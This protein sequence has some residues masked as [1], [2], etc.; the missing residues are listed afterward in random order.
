MDNYKFPLV[1]WQL[2]FSLEQYTVKGKKYM[3]N[4]SNAYLG[5][6]FKKDRNWV[7]RDRFS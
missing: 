3:K 1:N 7:Q 4:K 5:Y 2:D 6:L